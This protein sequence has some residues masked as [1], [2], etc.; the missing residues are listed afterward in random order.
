MNV[1]LTGKLQLI[2]FNIY[3]S[4]NKKLII[5]YENIFSIFYVFYEQYLT[6][7]YDTLISL[8]LS[9][10][11]VFVVTFLITGLDL[12]SA[13]VVSFTVFLILANMGGMMYWWNITL[14]AVS[15]VNLVV[16]SKLYKYYSTKRHAIVYDLI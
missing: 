7:W 11:A 3:L 9:Q 14:N 10:A 4:F 13:S 5:Y 12:H 6:I 8:L 16:V 2:L 15:L 1:F